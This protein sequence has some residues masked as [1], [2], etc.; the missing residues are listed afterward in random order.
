MG[1]KHTGATLAVL[2]GLCLVAF[3]YGLR[4][5]SQPFGDAELVEPEPAVCEWRHLE[6]GTTISPDEVTVSV[7]NAGGQSG[8]ASR[9]LQ[10]LIERG[11]GAGVSGNIQA[12]VKFVQVWAEDRANPAAKLVAGQFGPRTLIVAKDE[13]PG[14]GVVVVIGPKLRPLSDEAPA[15]VTTDEPV[16]I[17]SPPVQ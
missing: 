1:G 4:A 3:F 13:L 8:A 15:E 12:E 7:Y 10:A 9:T 2:V 14:N 5:V 16:S 17:C 11:F 6:A